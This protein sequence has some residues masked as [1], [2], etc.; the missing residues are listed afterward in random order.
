MGGI[1]Q[2]LLKN[3]GGGGVTLLFKLTCYIKVDHKIYVTKDAEKNVYA[4]FP[5]F[6]LFIINYI[7]VLYPVMSSSLLALS[8]QYNK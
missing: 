2:V 4:C 5:L 1:T 6:Y 8:T 7:H 3:W